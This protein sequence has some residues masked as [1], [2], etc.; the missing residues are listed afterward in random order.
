MEVQQQGEA[1]P[2]LGHIWAT[3]KLHF[4][5]IDAGLSATSTAQV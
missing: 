4:F 1:G 2:H 3:Q 5:D